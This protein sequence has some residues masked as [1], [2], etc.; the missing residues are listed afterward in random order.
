MSLAEHIYES[1][2][3]RSET[4][5]VW[6]DVLFLFIITIIHIIY[7][8]K[9]TIFSFGYLKAKCDEKKS[10]H[11]WSE[12]RLYLQTILSNRTD[13][14]TNLNS[15]IAVI[16]EQD[17]TLIFSKLWV[18]LSLLRNL[19]KILLFVCCCIILILYLSFLLNILYEY[20]VVCIVNYQNGSFLALLIL[21]FLWFVNAS[22]IRFIIYG[23]M[24]SWSIN[25][26][27][28]ADNI[29]YQQHHLSLKQYAHAHD[30]ENPDEYDSEQSEEQI[31]PVNRSE[32]TI[33][34][35]EEH[36]TFKK[37]IKGFCSDYF[38]A[39]H[40]RLLIIG[41]S[42]IATILALPSFANIETQPGTKQN[43]QL[44]DSFWMQL[45][46][47]YILLAM[48]SW[49]CL[50]FCL[51]II[52]AIYGRIATLSVYNEILDAKTPK[53]N[54]IN[55]QQKKNAFLRLFCL[56]DVFGIK[57][58][59]INWINYKIIIYSLFVFSG[60]L[61]IIIGAAI[62][63]GL[64]QFVGIINLLYYGV[65]LLL[66]CKVRGIHYLWRADMVSLELKNWWYDHSD[67]TEDNDNKKKRGHQYQPSDSHAAQMSV[68]TG[69]QL[70]KML[71]HYMSADSD[72]D[73]E[74]IIDENEEEKIHVIDHETPD[75]S[76]KKK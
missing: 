41:L 31:E 67:D 47:R 71:S 21:P 38:M 65:Q 68:L 23:I 5:P 53:A 24:V 16:D 59:H 28:I 32:G 1:T 8:S 2:Q 11:K 22:L 43:W 56:I 10:R 52:A 42:A 74:D 75:E 27:N 64:I 4:P 55:K 76:E 50:Y 33:M 37:T 61:C 39:F 3:H 54:D 13:K 60:I 36:T 34:R 7:A 25:V 29:A 63:N 46:L 51:S 15:N 6:I 26:D 30:D 9:F 58:K 72:S 45:F 70:H 66:N 62:Q 49:L 73:E 40:W 14:Y 44:T 17:L 48:T 12:E 35:E 69:G 18:Q 19:L 20:F 57:D